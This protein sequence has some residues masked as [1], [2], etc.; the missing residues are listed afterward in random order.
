MEGYRV[1]VIVNQN[2]KVLELQLHF[3]FQFFDY[4]SN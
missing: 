2:L 4:P 1:I 3:L